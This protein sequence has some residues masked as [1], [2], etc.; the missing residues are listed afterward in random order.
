M[1]ADDEGIKLTKARRPSVRIDPQTGNLLVNPRRKLLEL[2]EP[3]TGRL[4]AFEQLRQELAVAAELYEC[5]DDNRRAGME[6]ALL[7]VMMFAER[8]G[9][10]MAATHPLR[11]IMAAITD[12]ENGVAT[13]AFTPARK[14]KGGRPPKSVLTLS[15]E[16]ALATV[17]ELC[18]RHCR[19][20][21]KRPY[22][23][24][25]LALA[26]TLINRSA[27][28]VKVS[29]VELREMRE[30]IRAKRDGDDKM[31]FEIQTSSFAAKQ[32]PLDYAMM[33]INHDWLIA[34]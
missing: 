6:K 12:A 33:L 18:I 29:K 17:A 7:A 13:P 21:G 28:G 19:N 2:A 23:D 15:F 16:G 32:Y 20:E 9:I 31:Q 26:V 3:S 5:I 4:A 14:Q 25:G 11:A 34:E 30:R 24:Q 10:P 27:T 22:V 8:R 1:S